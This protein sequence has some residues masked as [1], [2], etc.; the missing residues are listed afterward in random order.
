[1]IFKK[2]FNYSAEKKCFFVCDT[3]QQRRQT[4]IFAGCL[5][6]SVKADGVSVKHFEL[7]F[8]I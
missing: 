2:K 8:E 4:V 7:K 6:D 1:M 5:G 3:E